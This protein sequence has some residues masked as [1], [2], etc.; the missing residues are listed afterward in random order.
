MRVDLDN[1]YGTTNKQINAEVRVSVSRNCS[2]TQPTAVVRNR[3]AARLTEPQFS[4]LSM[5]MSSS[6]TQRAFGSMHRKRESMPQLKSGVSTQVHS[7]QSPESYPHSAELLSGSQNPVTQQKTR[8]HLEN[9]IRQK[10]GA[11]G[12]QPFI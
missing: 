11:I 1:M 6:S 5:V 10:V 2:H 8:S 12:Q 7:Q 3:L 9:V 4:K